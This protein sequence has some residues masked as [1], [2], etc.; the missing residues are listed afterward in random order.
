MLWRLTG[1]SR[2]SLGEI[3]DRWIGRRRPDRLPQGWGDNI[4]TLSGIG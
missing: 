2:G 3:A 1:L 4:T